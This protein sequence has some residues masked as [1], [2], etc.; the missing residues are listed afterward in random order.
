MPH[1]WVL[2]DRVC[3]CGCERTFRVLPTSK[4]RFFSHWHEVGSENYFE[5]L[6]K[7]PNS[8]SN[9]FLFKHS[10]APEIIGVDTD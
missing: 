1:L 9:E 10:I 7:G 4:A 8:E 3:A 2:E 5:R 6:S